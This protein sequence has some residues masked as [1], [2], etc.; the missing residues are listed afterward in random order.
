MKTNKKLE[1]KERLNLYEGWSSIVTI[2]YNFP[3]DE[4]LLLGINFRRLEVIDY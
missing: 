1:E 2:L 4:M 3:L